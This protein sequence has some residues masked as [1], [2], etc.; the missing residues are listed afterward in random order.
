LAVGTT[1]NGGDQ[2]LGQFFDGDSFGT[3]INGGGAEVVFNGSAGHT[4]VVKGTLVDWGPG[5]TNDV[6]GQVFAGFSDNATIGT[7]GFITV[8]GAFA[9]DDN[10]TLNGGGEFVL[11][12]ATVVGT[13]V[14]DGSVLTLTGSAVSLFVNSNGH[15]HQPQRD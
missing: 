2:V 15:Y 4:N 10:S 14:N 13:T 1:L 8:F 11:D 7:G 3:V 6:T 12:N 5:T 9:E